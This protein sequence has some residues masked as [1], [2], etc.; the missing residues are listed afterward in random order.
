MIVVATPGRQ[1]AAVVANPPLSSVMTTG[2]HPVLRQPV[3]EILGL[4]C[5][6]RLIWVASQSN[7]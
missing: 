7:R 6:K 4:G 5:R 2:V 3:I 1:C